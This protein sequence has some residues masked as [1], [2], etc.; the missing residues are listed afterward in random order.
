MAEC[1]SST[2]VFSVLSGLVVGL[3]IGAAVALLYAPQS[4]EKTREDLAENID[5]L[6]ERIDD[7]T[8]KVADETKAR[9][10]ETK[11]DLVEAVEA[12]R[13]AATEKAQQLRKKAGLA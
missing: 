4:G 8:Q 13:A 10:V 6:R 9:F 11:A 1:D 5:D 2:S 12:G 7:L 3:A